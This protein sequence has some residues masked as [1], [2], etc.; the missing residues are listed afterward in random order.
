MTSTWDEPQEGQWRNCSNPTSLMGQSPRRSLK[1]NVNGRSSP[2]PWSLTQAPGPSSRAVVE[3]SPPPSFSWSSPGSYSRSRNRPY[4]PYV[5][6]YLLSPWQSDLFLSSPRPS[7][8]VRT[9]VR[10]LSSQC[11]YPCLVS[12][13]FP[14]RES[15]EVHSRPTSQG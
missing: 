8:A 6:R 2:C 3:L 13:V 5:G 11:L 1:E 4:W 15:D 9:R 12:H 14:L 7:S 10:F